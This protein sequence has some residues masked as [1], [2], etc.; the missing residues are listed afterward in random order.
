MM[1][2][3]NIAS[4]I[5]PELKGQGVVIRKADKSQDEPTPAPDVTDDDPEDETPVTGI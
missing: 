4:V 5:K 2:P 1:D 3:L